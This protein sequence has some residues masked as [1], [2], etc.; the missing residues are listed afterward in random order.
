MP[1]GIRHST[2]LSWP[3]D[4]QDKAL[5]YVRAQALVC[6]GCGTRMEEWDPERGGSRVAYVGESSRCLG[7]EVIE[8]E[9]KNVEEGVNT[10]GMRFFLVKNDNPEAIFEEE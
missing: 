9:K 2:F 8:R 10:D 7:C 1:L 4:D 6:R 5:G 3:D